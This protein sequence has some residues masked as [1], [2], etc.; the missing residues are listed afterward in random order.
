MRIRTLALVAA[1]LLG[2]GLFTAGTL[3]AEEFTNSL[4]MKMIRI[5]PGSFEMGSTLGR[6]YWDEQPVHKVTI[7]RGFYISETE[8]T[9]E[10]FRQFKAEFTGTPEHLPYAA[11]VSWYDAGAFCQLLSKKEGRP[12]R[13]PTEAEWEYACRAGTTTLYWSGRRAPRSGQ[14]NPWGLKNTHTGVREW[15]LDWH[16]EYPAA[17]QVD[18]VGPEYGMAR[19]VRGGLLDDGGKN[20]WREI[21]NA[22]SSRAA[23]APG[24]GPYYNESAA[25]KLVREEEAEE[26]AEQQAADLSKQ[27]YHGLTGIKYGNK[28]M[29]STKGQ[30]NLDTLDKV[31][32]PRV[33]SISTRWIRCGEAATMTG[34]FD[35]L[36]ILRGR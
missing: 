18:P 5:R 10:Q 30:L 32:R 6:D 20:K 11:G 17:E 23:I 31:W 25:N 33:N 34:R 7:S 35:G 28:A 19:V 22:S 14:A 29:K 8:V 4:G 1:C 13:L 12:Y 15:C 36:D 24:F 26:K 3:E 16:G 9:A 2:T 27:V 21:F